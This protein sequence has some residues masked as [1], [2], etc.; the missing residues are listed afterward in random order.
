MKK[1]LP[2]LFVSLLFLLFPRGVYAVD[3]SEGLSR[4]GCIDIKAAYEEVNVTSKAI[5]G[6]EK[7]LDSLKKA[8]SLATVTNLISLFLGDSVFCVNDEQAALKS[9]TFKSQGLIGLFDTGNRSIVSMFPS[10]NVGNHLA[11]E[12]VPGYNGNNSTQAGWFDD[13]K[14][15]I[16]GWFIS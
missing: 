9:D 16:M 2:I 10:V 7:S 5:T 1:L 11:Q 14:N 13:V 6:E 4:R 12:F 3:T 8:E 15:K